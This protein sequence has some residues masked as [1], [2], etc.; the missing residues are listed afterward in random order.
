[1]GVDATNIVSVG[2]PVVG[3][4]VLVVDEVVVKLSRVILDGSEVEGKASTF[5]VTRSVPVRRPV[6]GGAVTIMVASSEGVLNGSLARVSQWEADTEGEMWVATVTR[7]SIKMG[8][9]LGAPPVV[10]VV[11]GVL[12]VTVRV[13]APT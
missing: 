6:G 2:I 11:E 7:T 9:P 3:E 5:S 8:V 10:G 12:K 1:M 13:T 4:V